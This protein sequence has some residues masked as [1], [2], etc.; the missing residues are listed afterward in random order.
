MANLDTSKSAVHVLERAVLGTGSPDTT[1]TQ[2]A[3]KGIYAGSFTL[4]P[5]SATTGVTVTANA[6]IT[7][8]AVG[9]VVVL[10][11]PAA[12]NSGLVVTAVVTAAN[13]VAVRH[14]NVTAGTLD[15]ASGVYTYLWIDLT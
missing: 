14:S 1:N 12:L 10:T 11:G 4:D 5:A 9:D 13:T 2:I 3:V 8:V 7:G 6:T 15:A